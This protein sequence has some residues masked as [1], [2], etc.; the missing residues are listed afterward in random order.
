MLVNQKLP[1]NLALYTMRFPITALVSITHRVTG[2]LL[3]LLMPVLLLALQYSLTS[4]EYFNWLAYMLHNSNLTKFL[5]WLAASAFFYHVVAGLRH[6]LMDLHIGESHQGGRIGAALVF[7][8]SIAI[9]LVL[10]WQLW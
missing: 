4:I 9:A 7:S 5:L 2:V 3:Y 6:L 10:G 8:I 1:V